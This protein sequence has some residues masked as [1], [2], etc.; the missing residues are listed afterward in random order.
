[1]NSE[2]ALVGKIK[3]NIRDLQTEEKPAL[4]VDLKDE[5]RKQVDNPDRALEV[6]D[7]LR[8]H[9]EI[10]SYPDG[11]HTVVKITDEQL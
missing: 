4:V 3:Q 10:Y 9:G 1:M 8:N 6:Y 2:S 11:G 7:R 5:L